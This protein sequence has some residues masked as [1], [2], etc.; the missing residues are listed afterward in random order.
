MKLSKKVTAILLMGLMILGL[1]GCGSS[2]KREY[3]HFA[4]MAENPPF[5]FV[6]AKGF[7]GQYDGIDMELVKAIA[8]ENHYMPAIENMEVTR[9]TAAL[10][11]DQAEVAI[12]AITAED[13]N[14]KDAGFSHVYYDAT[15]V[16]VAKE[17]DAVVS[18]LELKEKRICAVK[19][20]YDEEAMQAA[21]LTVTVVERSSEAVDKL[22]GGECDV[23]LADASLAKALEKKSEGLSVG[24]YESLSAG[25]QYVVAVKKGNTALLEKINAVIDAMLEDGRMED[26]I[27]KY[28]DGTNS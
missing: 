14:V 11:N 4:A 5:A 24:G 12:G 27:L 13:E 17:G 20:F 9:Y 6:N 2:E 22:T 18:S 1:T 26:A 21:G 19:G 25:K 28:A 7:F 8:A 16:I 15:Q 3:I 10:Q 23:I